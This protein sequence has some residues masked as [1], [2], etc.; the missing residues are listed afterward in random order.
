[1]T[2]PAL[3][4]PLDWVEANQQYVSAAL[5]LLRAR[6][7]LRGQDPDAK[8][9]ARASAD[10][11]AAR[12]AMPK[13]AALDVVAGVFGLSDFERDVLLLCAGVELETA[14]ADLCAHAHDDPAQRHATFGL[15]LGALSDPHWSALTPASPLRRWH[16]VE[17]T[18]PE[19]LTASPLRIDERVLHAVAGITYLDPVLEPHA[20]PLDAPNGLASGAREAA[21][22]MVEAWSSSP[23][24]TVQLYGRHPADL[25][26]VAATAA[27]E[28]GM[29]PVR[30]DVSD[31]VDA[32]ADRRP[33][34]RLCE[35][36]AA[37]GGLAFVLDVHSAP[38]AIVASGLDLA[39]RLECPS[40]LVSRALTDREPR[41]VLIEVSLPSG[42]ESRGL[43]EQALGP[44]SALLGTGLDVVV[45]QF[46]LGA[47]TTRSVAAQVRP[48]LETG[49]AERAG[50]LLWRECRDQSRPA[51]DSLT[52]RIDPRARWADIVLPEPQLRTL[53]QVEAHVRHRL[54]V[55]EEWGFASRTNRGLGTA[56]L[57]AGPSG[58]G[59]SMAAEVLAHE[60][61]L[62][63]YRID[64]SQ[65]VSKYI[66]ETEKNLRAVFDAAEQG[67]AVL[68]FDEADALF[69]KR[70]EV[71][72]SHDR[73]ANIEVS[74]L[75]QRMEAYR[76][77]AILTTNLKG[78]L[79]Q[80]FWRRLRFVVQFPFPD[81]GQRAEIWR[82]TFPPDAP[83]EGLDPRRLA[84]LSV[85]GGTIANISLLA[86][87]LAAEAGE[88]IRMGHVRAA[89]R[90]EYA[91]LER[92]LTDAEVRGWEG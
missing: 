40:V 32:G 28:L 50:A 91:K 77:L 26:A 51:L 90:T 47:E 55:Q 15:C 4:R 89:A 60:L 75:L 82:R 73:Y 8:A 29:R 6:M 14:V 19:T 41:P 86:A 79:D 9:I 46:D 62:D 39:A 7:R 31:L 54:R 3:E 59:K 70:S 43:W 2:L 69:G 58:T 87:Y 30:L 20:R 57:F 22:R 24:T 34:V 36:E 63:L 92:P 38:P 66:G 23:G 81:A 18:H 74:Y 71:K 64:L 42:V 10:E 68:L 56:A 17:V 44:R 53:R 83:T 11:R 61:D 1:M 85:S 25:L 5:S 33:V 13:P 35:R 27:E 21:R 65:V 78:A 80:A 67:G 88:P 37:L 45:G 84:G 16:L 48:L 76:G 12:A 52:Q 72:D 49:D